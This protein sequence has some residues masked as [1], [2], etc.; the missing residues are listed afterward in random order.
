MDIERYKTILKKNKM[1]YE[2]LAKETGLSLGCIKRIMAGIAQFPRIDTIEAIERALGLDNRTTT[3]PPT[4]EKEEELLR[5]FRTMNP[6]R[7]DAAL[8]TVR[9]L[10]G[11]PKEAETVSKKKA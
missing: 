4:T 7:Q 9:I 3:T 10:A 8:D 6:A 2:D 1:T 5:I 11:L